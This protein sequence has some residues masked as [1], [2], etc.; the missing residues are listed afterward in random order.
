[1]SLTKIDCKFF[2]GGSASLD[3]SSFVVVNPRCKPASV[4]VSSA[5]AARDSI[6][7]QVACRLALEHFIDGVLDF[8]ENKLPDIE[9][10]AQAVE[11]EISVGVLEAAFKRANGSVYSFGHKLAAGGRMAATLIGLVLEDEVAA[12]GRVGPG[13]AYLYRRGEL[14]PFFD[15][16][17]EG[18]PGAG[19][20]VGSHSLISVEL[21]SVQIQQ[22]D[23]VL[24][25]SGSI[26]PE[27]EK[28]LCTLLD[29]LDLSE[30]DA[31]GL[32]CQNLFAG[33]S[34]LP[35]FMYARIGPDT[36]YLEHG[37]EIVE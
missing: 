14:F 16:G 22:K 23:T 37:M 1:M 32:I 3:K 30:S 24:L 26:D 33:H 29:D 13:S 8:Y 28:L 36:I 7:S 15:G 4:V 31:A 2:R 12:A 9:N 5:C 25:F 18:Q 34:E 35:F 19:A 6:S 21:A 17:S 10:G 27:Q 11:R 20:L